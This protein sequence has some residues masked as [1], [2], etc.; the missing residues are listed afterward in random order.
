MN[1]ETVDPVYT[2]L[3]KICE[4]QTVVNSVFHHAQD[5]KLGPFHKE[6]LLLHFCKF[7]TFVP[8]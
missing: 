6:I 4:V 3:W 7:Q 8:I 2:V 1:W 5:T